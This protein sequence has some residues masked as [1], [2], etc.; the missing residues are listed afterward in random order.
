MKTKITLLFAA[1]SLLLSFSNATAQNLFGDGSFESGTFTGWRMLEIYGNGIGLKYFNNDAASTSVINTDATDATDGTNSVA[2][3]WGDDSGMTAFLDYRFD[4]NVAVEENKSYTFA[5]DAK[6]S[7][8][9]IIFTL[10]IEWYDAVGLISATAGVDDRNFEVLENAAYT[11]VN[12][13][14][15]ETYMS[16]A[17]ATEATVG[18][19]ARY[20]DG[21]GGITGLAIDGTTTL[22]DNWIFYKTSTLGNEDHVAFDFSVYPNPATDVVNIQSKT[23]ISNIQ[24]FNSLGQ[25]VVDVDGKSSIDI[26]GLNTGLYVLNATD[27]EGNVGVKRVIKQ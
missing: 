2:V 10:Y 7:G 12:G 4:S 6:T 16:P 21:S 24:L 25:K 27:T 1:L 5:F 18:I 13:G 3:T 22:L 15:G 23:A 20:S 26:S 9:H 17:G 8:R 14:A 11:T 19:K